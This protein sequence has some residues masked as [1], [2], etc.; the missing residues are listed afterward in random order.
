MDNLTGLVVCGGQSCRMGM[1]KS[2]LDYYGKPHSHYL[3]HLLQIFCNSVYLS[4]NGHQSLNADIS[5]P[6]ITDEPEYCNAG[7]MTALL[8]AWKKYPD[9]SLLVIGC[10]YMFV[11]NDAIMTLIQNRKGDATCFTHPD[12]NIYEPLLTIYESSF[13]PVVMKNFLAQN[14]SLSKI[15]KRENIT[16]ILPAT[17]AM[18][19]NANTKAEYLTAKKMIDQKI[20]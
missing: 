15:L 4:L 8:S 2:M 9:T 13:Y 16:S 10:D 11:N 3:Y 5:Y 19:E 14:Y 17:P 1:D 12:S 20:Y 18:L 7:P 6:Y